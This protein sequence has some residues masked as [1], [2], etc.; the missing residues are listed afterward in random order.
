MSIGHETKNGKTSQ[1]P[2][3]FADGMLPN[4]YEDLWRC[5]EEAECVFTDD[6][7]QMAVF[8][9]PRLVTVSSFYHITVNFKYDPLGTLDE[10]VARELPIVCQWLAV[11]YILFTSILGGQSMQFWYEDAMVDPLAW[12]YH[13]FQSVGLQLPR[14]VVED[15]A[16]AAVDDNMAFA[17]KPVDPHPGENS[18]TEEGPPRF[19]DQVSAATLDLA[20]DILRTWLSPVL[21]ERFGVEP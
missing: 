10:F 6:W 14:G 19:E 7:L 21:L 5:M 12:H 16:Q 11:R 8:R 9:D 3:K 15:T 17:H 2:C 20:D 1:P 4:D 13:W 18:T